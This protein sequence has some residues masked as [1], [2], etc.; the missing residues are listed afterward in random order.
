MPVA[1]APEAQPVLTLEPLQE[2][3]L[4]KRYKR[5]LA[6]VQLDTGEVVTAHCANTGPMTGVLRRYLADQGGQTE[7]ADLV[8][9]VNDELRDR[10]GSGDQ[11]L[12]PSHFM[13][14]GLDEAMMSRIW[15]YNVE[16][17]IDDV[18]YGDESTIA[19]FHW[20][21]VL[22]RFRSGDTFG[23]ESGGGPDDG[24]GDSPGPDGNVGA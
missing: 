10:L 11:L 8:G 9:M 22:R 3:V 18:F 16:P 6:D 5:F 20:S 17:F 2:G 1:A 23:A 19:E 7:W 12:G 4:L 15:R 24:P 13:K 14:A 21:A